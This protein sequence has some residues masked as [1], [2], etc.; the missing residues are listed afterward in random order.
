MNM[1]SWVIDWI[2]NHLGINPI[3]GGNP[4]N[5]IKFTKSESLTSLLI[6]ILEINCFRKKAF[7]FFIIIRILIVI[8]E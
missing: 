3:N 1:F 5:D 6:F 7:R 8:I 2:T 4:P